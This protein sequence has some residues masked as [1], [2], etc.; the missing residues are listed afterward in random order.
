MLEVKPGDA[1]SIIECD[2]SVEFAA[3]VGYQPPEFKKEQTEEVSNNW[4]SFSTVS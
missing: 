4:L 2:M 1:V 3:P